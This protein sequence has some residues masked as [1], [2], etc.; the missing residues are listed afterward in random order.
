MEYNAL[1]PE[2]VAAIKNVMNKIKNIAPLVKDDPF[3]PKVEA[4]L[5]IAFEM[6]REQLLIDK[7]YNCKRANQDDKFHHDDDIPSVDDL[8][9][10]I[11]GEGDDEQ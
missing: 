1:S 8:R 6:L 5:E 10:M 11:E 2:E 3:D 9:R 4:I 7:K